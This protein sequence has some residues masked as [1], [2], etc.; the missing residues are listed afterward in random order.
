MARFP[1]STNTAQS[2]D[3]NPSENLW[4]WFENPCKKTV[5]FECHQILIHLILQCGAKWKSISS[6]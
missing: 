3:L 6:Q 4:N 2:P 1:K 5:N